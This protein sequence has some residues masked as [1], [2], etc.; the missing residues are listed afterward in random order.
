VKPENSASPIQQSLIPRR[1]IIFTR[2]PRPG[3][4]K[5]R[6]NPGLGPEGAA[7]LHRRMVEHT[8]GWARHLESRG[9]TSLEVC[10]D[11]AEEMLFQ[12]W[13]GSD[14]FFRPQGSGDLGAR[15]ARA[16]DRAFGCGRER[17]I[18]VGTD[19]PD[20]G[21]NLVQEA[22]EALRDH[23]LVLG[24]AADG[25]YY[26][27]GLRR[28]MPEI[29]SNI[30]WGTGEVLE[31]TLQAARYLGV[32]FFLTRTLQDVDRPED[33]PAWERAAAGKTSSP[34][35]ISVII[36]TLNEEKNI[37]PCLESTGNDFNVERIVVDGGS[38]DRTQAIALSWGA[39][40]VRAPTGR[41]RQMNAGAKSAGGD[42]LLFLH[43]D[44]RLPAAF[45]DTVRY[46]LTIPGVVAGAFEFR[47]D[48]TSPGL[49][50]IERIANWRSR[51]LQLPYGDQGIFLRSSLFR[52]GGGF[53]DIPIMED[54]EFIQ[55]LKKYGR[56][57]T[58]PAPAVT[59][60]RRWE[61]LGTWKATWVNEVALIAYYLGVSPERILRITRGHQG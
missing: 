53:R 9:G 18:L 14:L 48:A 10:Y 57:L 5:T 52:E 19:V 1:L 47:L 37:I 59:S 35:S 41:A 46:A 60:A 4:T 58:V 7:A 36:P 50:L 24:P 25:G 6:L 22:F 11:G 45:A 2:Y 13:L 39:K 29:F 61:K 42:L 54:F 51:L 26:L 49:R 20:L 56:I 44:T 12:N 8:L 15:M 23:D 3:G 28:P 27:V 34:A 43:A 31:K 21:E 32:R 40:V 33:L 38:R 55:R 30:P 17:V 16:F